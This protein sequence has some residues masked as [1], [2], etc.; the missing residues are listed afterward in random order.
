MQRSL[1]PER[2]PITPDV[3]VAARYIPA[4]RDVEIGGDWYDV[5]TLPQ[6]QLGIVIGDVAGHGVAAAAAMGQM[7]MALRTYALDGLPPAAAL[8]RL[9]VLMHEFQ[10]G[11]VATLIYAH[12]DPESGT[13][14]LA[15]AGHPPPLLVTASGDAI[16][17][18]G[19]LG[20]PLGVDA[21]IVYQ[22]VVAQLTPGTTLVL[23]TDGLIE[24]RGESLDRGMERLRAALAS[25]PEDLEAASD[26][27]VRLLIP[28]GGAADDTALLAVRR[29]SLVDRPLQLTLPAQP[30]RLAGVRRI[31]VRWLRQNG[32]GEDDASEILV[33]CTEA[34]AN[35][36]R[37]AYGM[38]EGAMQIDAAFQGEDL[39]LSVRDFGEWRAPDPAAPEDRGRGLSMIRGLMHAVDIVTGADG[40]EVRMRRRVEKA[41]A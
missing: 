19:G 30:P 17:V 7:R 10:P 3:T 35:V 41:D 8:Q 36:M 16:F 5:I 31:L 12:L 23:Y 38:E 15:K 29:V 24:R 37:H 13:L 2:F 40:T 22:E 28:E 6:G 4:G 20:P 9:N 26:H 1:L 34:C 11:A 25:A 21:G 33:A 27:V 32:V 14:R 39:S 18:E